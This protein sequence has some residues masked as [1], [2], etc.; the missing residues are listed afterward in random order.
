MTGLSQEPDWNRGD[1]HA[2]AI[3]TRLEASGRNV[4]ERFGSRMSTRMR[5]L[6]KSRPEGA[7]C[8]QWELLS[9]R[10]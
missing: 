5:A 1:R 9:T 4:S 3:D 6:P 10:C 8:G 2:L 7:G